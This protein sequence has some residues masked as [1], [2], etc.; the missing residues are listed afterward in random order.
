MLACLYC[1]RLVQTNA[2]DSAAAA[3]AAAG[4]EASQSCA[5]PA[6]LAALARFQHT[7]ALLVAGREAA[8]A[9]CL[10]SDVPPSCPSVTTLAASTEVHPTAAVA[11]VILQPITPFVP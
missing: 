5:A 11:A 2:A 8:D 6:R 3:A 9:S 4:A 7:R 1:A 10:K